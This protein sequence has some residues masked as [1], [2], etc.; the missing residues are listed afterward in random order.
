MEKKLK[1]IVVE[2]SENDTLLEIR[3]IEQAGYRVKYL[4]VETKEELEAALKADEWDVV[5]SDFTM[6]HF[7]GAEAL[8]LVRSKDD[9]IP[10]IFVSGTIGEDRAVKTLK[11]GASDY[12]LKID[13]K[14]LVS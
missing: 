3:L 14:R 11:D 6:P 7:S 13:P 10:F 8:K 9:F 2:D 12:I 1:I 5:L 4:R